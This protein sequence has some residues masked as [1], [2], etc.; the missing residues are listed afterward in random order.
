VCL[1]IVLAHVCDGAP[2]VVAANRDELLDRPATPMAVLRDAAPR[3][4]G[5]R[6]EKAGGTWLAVNEHGV[7]AGLTNF[8]TTS[9]PDSSKRS[10]G[11][12]PIT[13]AIHT[14]AHRAVDALARTVRP[15]EYNP[16]WMIVAD[17]EDAFAVDIT[18]DTIGFLALGP[19]IHILEN[20]PYAAPSPKVD[21]VRS[22]LNGIEQTK[23]EVMIARLQQALGNHTIPAG[24]SAATEVGR[25]GVP[26]E[27]A[28]ACVHT[29]RYGTRWSGIVTLGPSRD[30]PS[31]LFAPGP[32]CSTPF[33]D[34]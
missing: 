20:R 24:V 11:E 10:R 26:P 5:G 2:L 18:G 13:A 23:S 14:T 30:V 3:V 9:G 32:P 21:H 4:V 33:R 7:V 28:A 31:V 6:D 19:G 8:P 27:V 1:L 25:A 34:G 17:R 12:L 16:A 29:D 22:L 15:D